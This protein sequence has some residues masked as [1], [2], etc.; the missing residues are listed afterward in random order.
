MGIV[1]STADL[2]VLGQVPGVEA[3]VGTKAG[4][5]LCVSVGVIQRYFERAVVIRSL[6]YPSSEFKLDYLDTAGRRN[7]SV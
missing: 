4:A 7:Q 2:I 6:S 3:E 5:G 1:K